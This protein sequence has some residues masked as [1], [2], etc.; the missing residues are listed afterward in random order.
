MKEAAVTLD[1][2]LIPNDQTKAMN[3]DYSWPKCGLGSNI[4]G[5]EQ[6]GDTGQQQRQE[7]DTV[8][9]KGVAHSVQH[10]GVQSSVGYYYLQRFFQARM[11]TGKALNIPAETH[12][13]SWVRSPRR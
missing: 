7:G 9:P 10:Q 2:R 12:D 6:L 13:Q 11:A 1:L 5:K 8:S 4:D 3:D